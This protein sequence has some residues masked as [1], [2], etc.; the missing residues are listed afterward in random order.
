MTSLLADDPLPSDLDSIMLRVDGLWQRLRDENLFITG[1]TGFFGRW[2]LESLVHANQQFKLN[3][4]ITVLTR[5]E[6][7]FKARAPQLAADA[8]ITFHRGDVTNFDFPEGRFSLLIHAATTSADETFHGEDPLRKFDTLVNGTRHTLEFAAASG[9]RR[10]L[11][12]SSGVAYGPPPPGAT[13][14][15]EDYNG[16]PDPSDTNSALGQAK[17]AAEFL[18]AY[19][20]QKH[21]MSYSVA[22]CFSFVG[23]FL[24]LNI[25]YAI[26]NFIDQ[27]LNSEAIVVKG[28]G[29][30]LR[31]YLY[32]ADLVTW[33]LKALLDGQ[34]ARVYNV[35]SDQAITI[36]EL[37]H[38]VRDVVSPG[39]PVEVLGEPSFSVG[40]V[41]R[42][43]YVPD[44]DRATNELGVDVWTAL[45]EA[46]KRT[47]EHASISMG[48]KGREM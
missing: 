5:D 46:I 12:I 40:N 2:L 7:A 11:L 18:C 32:M 6:K 4:K 47:A 1:G 15:N 14:I 45:P 43:V 10:I 41:V 24:P 25:H 21:Q 34:N 38:L 48:R 17:R 16:A 22:R 23:P 35:G 31:S 29:T 13:S 28:D 20:A 27:A 39:K 19:F 36:R 37:A 26:G 9:I 44:I 3:L 33:L 42:N 8:A 30:P